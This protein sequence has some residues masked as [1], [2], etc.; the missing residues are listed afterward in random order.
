MNCVNNLE[1]IIDDFIQIFKVFLR[2]DVDYEL[3]E[4]DAVC[5][6][7][8]ERK[9]GKEIAILS[10]QKSDMAGNESKKFYADNPGRDE[11]FEKLDRW[12]KKEIGDDCTEYVYDDYY[13]RI[14]TLHLINLI[15][16]KH[17]KIIKLIQQL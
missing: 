8:T 17:P 1:N 2:L 16:T 15:V 14:Y 7:L 11:G 9:T 5:V 10:L 13:C 12:L 6:T 3:F 4:E